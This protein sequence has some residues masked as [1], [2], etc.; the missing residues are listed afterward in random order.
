MILACMLLSVTHVVGEI[1]QFVG[2]L[3]C[4]EFVYRT[5]FDLAYPLAGNL[6][7]F[8]V[9]RSVYSLPAPF[10]PYRCF[11]NT[12]DRLYKMNRNPD[13]S[14]LVRHSST[15][16][17]LPDPPGGIRGEFVAQM[18]IEFIDCFH[19]SDIAFLDEIQ[20]VQPEVRI[21]SPC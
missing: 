16:D 14:S 15:R 13:R 20:V 10:I 19:Q 6:E 18:I 3:I 11:R 17:V 5:F 9:P 8:P 1:G 2:P 7:Y 21:F 12:V 4:A